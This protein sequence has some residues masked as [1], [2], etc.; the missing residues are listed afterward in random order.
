MAVLSG[1][2]IIVAGGGGDLTLAQYTST[3]A[4]DTSFDGDG[5]ATFNYLSF[6]NADGV[7]FEL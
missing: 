3:G 6:D 5:I 1:D 7:Q 4:P 2:G